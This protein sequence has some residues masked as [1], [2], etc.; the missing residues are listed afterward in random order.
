MKRTVSALAAGVL[1][2][3][4]AGVGPASATTPAVDCAAGGYT[5]VHT[6]YVPTNVERPA[7]DGRAYNIAGPTAYTYEVCLDIPDGSTFTIQVRIGPTG[8]LGHPLSRGQWQ[9]A[10]EGDSAGAG[11]TAC[12]DRP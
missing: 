8:S 2:A 9:A 4:L 11:V 3:T 10:R 7:I 6:S 12:F 5:R 1:G